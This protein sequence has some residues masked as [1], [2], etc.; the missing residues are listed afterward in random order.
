MIRKPWLFVSARLGLPR[1][2]FTVVVADADVGAGLPL[3]LA[4]LGRS[5]A[6]PAH[7]VAG[8][9]GHRRV[10]AVDAELLAHAVCRSV[11]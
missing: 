8:A 9:A 5:K 3:F 4:A 2:P 1:I 7:P 6:D 10:V 11:A